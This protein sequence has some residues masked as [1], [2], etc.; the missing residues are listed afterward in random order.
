MREKNCTLLFFL[1]ITNFINLSYSKIYDFEKHQIGK[2]PLGWTSGKTGKGIS[3]WTIEVDKYS[4]SSSKVL[5]QSARCDFAWC[6]LNNTSVENG[7]VEVK[8]KP[9]S[10]RID[11]AGGIVWRFKDGNNYYVTRAN[12]LENN[13]SLY[14][15]NKRLSPY[16]KIC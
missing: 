12:A 8:L 16:I 5:K 7:Y 3:I 1:F 13:V 11:Q 9:I 15:Y 2:L 10:G 4:P 14:I 6:V